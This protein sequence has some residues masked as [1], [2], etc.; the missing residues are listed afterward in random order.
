MNIWLIEVETCG[1]LHALHSTEE[2]H[3]LS[4]YYQ[5]LLHVNNDKF[6][7][8]SPGG[9]SHERRSKVESRDVMIHETS[10]HRSKLPLHKQNKARMV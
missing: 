9:E 2:F 10:A 8:D 4:Y 1:H 5:L 7:H 6:R 3:V